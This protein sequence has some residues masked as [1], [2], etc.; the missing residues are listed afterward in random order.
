MVVHLDEEVLGK[1]GE[2]C[3]YGKFVVQHPHKPESFTL[4]MEAIHSSDTL[5]VQKPQN[6]VINRSTTTMKT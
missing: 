2:C 4:K 3:W 6:K 1:R 5:M